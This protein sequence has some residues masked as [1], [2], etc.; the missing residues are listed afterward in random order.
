MTEHLDIVAHMLRS[1]W[2]QGPLL[3]MW[4]LGILWAVLTFKRHPRKSFLTMLVLAAFLVEAVAVP[5][6]YYFLFNPAEGT[7]N[8]FEKIWTITEFCRSVVD[9]GLWLLLFIALFLVDCPPGAARGPDGE[10]LPPNW[11]RERKGP[12]T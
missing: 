12:E 6:L 5:L 1:L 4:L 2:V 8:D 3:A 10:L 11:D 9:A 7:G